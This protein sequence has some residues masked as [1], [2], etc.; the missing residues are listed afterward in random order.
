VLREAEARDHAV[1]IDLLAS[2]EV[3]TY[4]GGPR[5]RDEL[6]RELPETPGKDLGICVVQL[7]G[8]MIGQVILRRSV[9]ERGTGKVELASLSTSRRA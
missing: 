2:P 6:E 4:L 7:D 5:A 9:E 8:A 3:H 1:F